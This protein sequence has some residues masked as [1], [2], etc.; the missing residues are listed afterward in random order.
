MDALWL[1]GEIVAI[2]SVLAFYIFVWARLDPRE[3]VE[4]DRKGLSVSAVNNGINGGLIAVSI[5]LPISLAIAIFAVDKGMG[6]GS[7]L[8][9]KM[10]SLYFLLSLVAAT[11]NLF[12]L[13][14]L[15]QKNIDIAYDHNTVYVEM[16]QLLFML[17]GAE[18]LVAAIWHI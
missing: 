8:H 4:T 11:W 5:L 13:P 18:R 16:A 9:V 14:T 1:I 15:V 6:G 10:A 17:L 7:I 2:V 12:R 3:L